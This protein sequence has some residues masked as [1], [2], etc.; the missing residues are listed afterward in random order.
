MH[1]RQPEHNKFFFALPVET[2]AA[3]ASAAASAEE[4][5]DDNAAFFE[6]RQALASRK[7]TGA[8]IMTIR[9]QNLNPKGNAKN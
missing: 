5:T 4:W 9:A 3:A 2:A 8:I 1:L 7:F 6:S